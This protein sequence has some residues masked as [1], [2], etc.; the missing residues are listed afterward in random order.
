[1]SNPTANLP[2]P[3]DFLNISP[4]ELTKKANAQATDIYND[5]KAIVD[6]YDLTDETKSKMAK[7]IS[8]TILKRLNVFNQLP[9][10]VMNGSKVLQDIAKFWQEVENQI[11]SF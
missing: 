5:A 1:M 7:G 9:Q 2:K 8:K 4:E 6:Q 11:D 10:E 3:E